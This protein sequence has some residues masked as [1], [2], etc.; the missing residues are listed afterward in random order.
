[1]WKGAAEILKNIAT[2][3]K[4][5][6]KVTAMGT[7]FAGATVCTI[8]TGGACAPLLMAALGTTASVGGTVA[9]STLTYELVQ[10]E[11]RP[12]QDAPNL[13][14]G[15]STEEQLTIKQMFQERAYTS[16]Y[17]SNLTTAQQFC[18]NGDLAGE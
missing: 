14:A 17:L 8:A 4:I 13:Q 3:T 11:Y 18:A 16:I 7:A 6:P 5:N 9:A 2:I 12:Q 10:G 15:L 1:M